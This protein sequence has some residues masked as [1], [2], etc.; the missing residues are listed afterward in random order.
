[1]A[2]ALRVDAPRINDIARERR[3]ITPDTILTDSFDFE[4][5][6][7]NVGAGPVRTVPAGPTPPAAGAAI[8]T[9]LPARTTRFAV[10]QAKARPF[11]ATS[12]KR[13]KQ[14]RS[15]TTE[16]IY[17]TQTGEAAHVGIGGMQFGL[18]LDSQRRQMCIRCEIS[19]GTG[20]LEQLEKNVRVSV[21]RVDQD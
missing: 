5:F 11:P 13:R 8:L 7:T 4:E 19:G 1:M 6:H 20:V 9:A 14:L 15:S 18:M 2:K 10:P 12:R 16:R 17:P 21:S 3:A